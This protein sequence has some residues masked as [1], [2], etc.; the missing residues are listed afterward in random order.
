V[1]TF[2][3]RDIGEREHRLAELYEAYAFWAQ[4]SELTGIDPDT[5]QVVHSVALERQLTP[6]DVGADRLWLMG[7]HDRGVLLMALNLQSLAF[8]GSIVLKGQ[9]AY[10]GSGVLDE[11]TS[12]VWLALYDGSV[13]RV[14]LGR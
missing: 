3:G 4:G 13:K 2:G 14:D 5:D 8:D 6:F 12:S 9:P 10:E 7:T 1:R 11:A